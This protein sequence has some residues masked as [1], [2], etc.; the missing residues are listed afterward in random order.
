MKQIETKG[1]LGERKK[2]QRRGKG[3]KCCQIRKVWKN[4]SK[5]IEK[6]MYEC[7][8]RNRKKKQD[9][10]SSNLVALPDLYFHYYLL[11]LSG[12]WVFFVF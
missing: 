11:L 1:R 2:D 7:E 12:F 5:E 4:G 6:E 10:N 9:F 3:I 8:K